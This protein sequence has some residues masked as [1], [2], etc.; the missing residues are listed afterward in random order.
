[1]PGAELGMHTQIRYSNGME[2]WWNF[3]NGMEYWKSV[4]VFEYFVNILEYYSNIG[5]RRN[6]EKIPG[7]W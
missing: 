5:K 4:I 6:T 1:M 3:P 7:K 2:Y